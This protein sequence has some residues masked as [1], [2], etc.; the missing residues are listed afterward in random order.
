MRLGEGDGA[1]QRRRD[2]LLGCDARM[3][4]LAVDLDLPVLLADRPDDQIRRVLAVDVDAHHGA[5]EIGGIELACAVQAAL[6]AD[7]EE[8]RD[9]RMR[10]VVLQ[11]RLGEDD[12]DGAAGAVVAAERRRAV[13]DD[14]V[15]L[16]PRLGAGA[17]RHGVEMG[18]EQQP[19]P[20]PRSGQI[21]DQV[22]GFGRHGNALVRFVEADRGGRHAGRLERVGNGRRDGGLLSGDAL[23]REKPHQVI[24][25]GGDIEGNRSAAHRLIPLLAVALLRQAA[26]R[27]LASAHSPH[28]SPSI[29]QMAKRAV[30]RMKIHTT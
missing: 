27:P 22:A 7:R 11:E 17:E 15:A 16:A 20:G 24:L 19:R 29:C 26:W 8:Q 25:R 9:R 18:R 28:G 5:A 30:Q 4:G 13:R 14:A 10:Q 12:E 1:D 23:D 2:A 3:R 21:D 6:L